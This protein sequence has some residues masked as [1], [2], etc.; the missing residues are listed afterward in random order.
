MPWL[1]TLQ[2]ASDALLAIGCMSIGSVMVWI[3]AIGRRPREVPSRALI[4]SL[5]VL[6]VVSGLL[7]FTTALVARPAD[8]QASISLLASISCWAAALALARSTATLPAASHVEGIEREIAE[9]QRAEAALLNSEAAARKLAEADARKNEFLAMLGHE[10]R[11]PLAPIRNAVKVSRSRG[12]P[13]GRYAFSA[14]R[15]MSRPLWPTL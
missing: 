7:Q 6:L 10:L 1:V 11:N 5:G 9:R 12:S 3:Y 4:W 13:A 8:R 14:S 15:S 2:Q